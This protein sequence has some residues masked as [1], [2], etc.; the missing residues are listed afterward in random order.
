MKALLYPS[1]VSLAHIATM[2]TLSKVQSFTIRNLIGLPKSDSAQP[3]N[4][5]RAELGP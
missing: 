5:A 3:R 2:V 4:H 1:Q